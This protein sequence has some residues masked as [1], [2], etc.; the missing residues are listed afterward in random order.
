MGGTIE[1]SLG[2]CHSE[3]RTKRGCLR[4][5]TPAPATIATEVEG[6][7]DKD[8]AQVICDR[9]LQFPTSARLLGF[10][11]WATLEDYEPEARRRLMGMCLVILK[12]TEAVHMM[13]T[14][15]LIVLGIQAAAVIFTP[16][17]LHDNPHS[18]A[19]E[20][21]SRLGLHR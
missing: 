4:V 14:H 19:H 9:T 20:M 6:Y 13:A 21:R 1:R 18:F 7:L 8:M 17:R 11:D 10:H 2:T 15:R 3:L 12:R 16:I 5:W